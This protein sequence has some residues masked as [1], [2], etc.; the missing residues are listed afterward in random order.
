MFPGADLLVNI[1]NFYM[2]QVRGDFCLHFNLLGLPR[3]RNAT[4]FTEHFHSGGQDG[5]KRF[6]EQNYRAKNRNLNT[7]LLNSV[8]M[9]FFY[10]VFDETNN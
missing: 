2:W 1:G 10:C 9:S 3:L 8:L 5:S 6:Q 4:D 7:S